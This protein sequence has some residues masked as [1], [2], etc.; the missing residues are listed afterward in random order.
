MAKDYYDITL[1][2]AGVA[3]VARLVQQLAWQGHC[4]QDAMKTSINSLFIVDPTTTISVYGS[5]ES[6]LRLGLDSLIATLHS[7]GEQA[8][9]AELKRYLL[10]LLIQAPAIQQNQTAFSLLTRKIA[11][12]AEAHHEYPPDARH[13]ISGM[14]ELYTTLIRHCNIEFKISGST[15]LDDPWIQQ[16]I[17]AVLLAGIRSV[18]LW[19]Q[20]GGTKMQLLYARKPLVNQ[21]KNLLNKVGPLY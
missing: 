9:T 2:L 19:R 17:R 14:A 4:D 10:T 7:R 5:D 13:T 8:V 20:S 1:A 11:H 15:A 16:Q 21:A 3:Q 6:C 12:Y 18:I